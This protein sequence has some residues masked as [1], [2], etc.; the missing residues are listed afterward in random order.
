MLMEKTL[1]EGLVNADFRVRMRTIYALV[2]QKHEEA[3]PMLLALLH[4]REMP[5]R[6]AA[7]AALGT[8]ANPQ[9]FEPLVAC[10]ASPITLERRNAVQALVAL[11]D[12][13]RCDA[14]LQA[15]KTE[16]NPSIR[17]AMIKAVSVFPKQEVLEGLM[18]RLGDREPYV[19]AVAAI[20]LGKMGQPRAIPAL[21]QMAL[22]DT[23]QETFLQ[24]GSE[25]NS[26][27]AQRAIGKIL[28]PEQEQ[29]LDWPG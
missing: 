21:Q 1:A 7:I 4:D 10:L 2:E 15:L 6:L 3:V 22:T 13:R 27:I 5:V 14:L 11:G 12:P 24:R 8:F 29:D 9:A 28:H 18:E 17:G 23:N 16:K 26:S 19:R 25:R 20:A